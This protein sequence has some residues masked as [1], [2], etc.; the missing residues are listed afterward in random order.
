[1]Y[2][3]NI[4][5]VFRG[6]IL[7][8]IISMKIGLIGAT[9]PAGKALAARLSS[10]GYEVTIGSRSK[11]RA[12]EIRDEIVSAWPEKELKITAA[13]N[14]DAAKADLIVIATPWDAAA[15][16]ARSVA[17]HLHGKIV[18]WINRSCL[19]IQISNVSI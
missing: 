7:P 19:V 1:M 16:A 11:Y 14:I 13:E 17:E 18:I 5:L 15:T 9:G 3:K 4:P 8:K 12:L 6:S 10:V 2:I